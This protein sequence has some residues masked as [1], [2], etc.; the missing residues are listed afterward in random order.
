MNNFYLDYCSGPSFVRFI[1]IQRVARVV[2]LIQTQSIVFVFVFLRTDLLFWV[3]ISWG[4]YF[5]FGIFFCTDR[6]YIDVIYVVLYKVCVLCKVFLSCLSEL[7][8]PPTFL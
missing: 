6:V 1:E 8:Q 2:R 4:G 5:F 7:G 3:Y